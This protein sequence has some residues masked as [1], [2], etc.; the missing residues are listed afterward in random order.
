MRGVA[1][2]SIKRISNWSDDVYVWLQCYAH[3][4]N[5]TTETLTSLHCSKKTDYRRKLHEFKNLSEYFFLKQK[6]DI[7]LVTAILF[8]SFWADLIFPA[9]V[10]QS[11]L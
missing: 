3:I 7:V 10:Q 9:Y 8:A 4:L 11:N 6:H 2:A 5:V 1:T